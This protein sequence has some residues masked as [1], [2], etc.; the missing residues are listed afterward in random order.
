MYRDKQR[1]GRQHLYRMLTAVSLMLCDH[2]YVLF[3]Y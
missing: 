1:K 3:N 2:N